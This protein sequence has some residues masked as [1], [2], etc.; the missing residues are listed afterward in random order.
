LGSVDGRVGDG[1]GV[2]GWRVRETVFVTHDHAPELGNRFRAVDTL[3]ALC[4]AQV[5]RK[6]IRWRYRWRWIAMAQR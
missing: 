4:V 5:A 3:P 2:T 6:H 1:P